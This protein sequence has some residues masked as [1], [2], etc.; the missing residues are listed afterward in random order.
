MFCF[1]RLWDYCDVH[2]GQYRS[3][4]GPSWPLPFRHAIG[5]QCG[6]LHP[7]PPGVPDQ[8]GQF[9]CFWKLRYFYQSCQPSFSAVANLGRHHPLDRF[10]YDW[11]LGVLGSLLGSG[12][13]VPGRFL[14]GIHNCTP[15]WSLGVR[16]KRQSCV[17]TLYYHVGAMGERILR[18][19]RTLFPR[20]HR[21]LWAEDFRAGYFWAVLGRYLL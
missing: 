19:Q 2:Y 12:R 4:Y 15:S 8:S 14:R 11:R 7:C 20:F 16:H 21:T 13:P 18:Y 1:L 6:S 10:R 9:R 17:S 5:C 3:I